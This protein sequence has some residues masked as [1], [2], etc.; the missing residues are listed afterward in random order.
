MLDHVPSPRRALLATAL[1]LV[2]PAA[3]LAQCP[4]ADQVDKTI[5]KV[6]KNPAIEARKVS[7]APFKGLCEIQ[8][9]FQGRPNVLY[10]DTA[11]AHFVT[12]H[13]IEVARGRDLTEET[14]GAL[15]SLSAEEMKKVDAFVAMT[16]GTKGPAVYFVTD[17]L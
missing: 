11:G 6:F 13:L 5:K 9:T 7:P 4:P 16:V 8:V 17:P 12:G 10:T 2:L 1:G 3:A 15:S 14:I